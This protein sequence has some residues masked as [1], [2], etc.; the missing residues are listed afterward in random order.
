MSSNLAS[1]NFLSWLI[2]FISGPRAVIAEWQTRLRVTLAPACT[3]T[4]VV[5]LISVGLP[6]AAQAAQVED[7]IDNGLVAVTWQHLITSNISLVPATKTRLCQIGRL[8]TGDLLR[9][10]GVRAP[11]TLGEDCNAT[12]ELGVRRSPIA[13]CG[14]DDD[15]GQ[16]ALLIH[17]LARNRD[18]LGHTT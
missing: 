12:L 8:P 6:F 15:P 2:S 5:L 17:T 10:A 11:N 3:L 13:N 7:T 9:G 16:P 14:E 1:R 4:A 18:S